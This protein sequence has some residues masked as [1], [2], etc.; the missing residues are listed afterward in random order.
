MGSAV[1][2]ELV[3]VAEL[4]FSHM[5]TYLYVPETTRGTPP[6]GSDDNEELLEKH[7][8]S[9]ACD[10]SP[11]YVSTCAVRSVLRVVYCL[12]VVPV[13]VLLLFASA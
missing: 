4:P 12:S 2:N 1:T 8:T 10:W 9:C 5:A 3:A 11:L 6:V 13:H 7:G